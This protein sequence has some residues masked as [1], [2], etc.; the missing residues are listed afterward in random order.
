MN[1]YL[2]QE[3]RLGNL[4]LKY[5]FGVVLSQRTNFNFYTLFKLDIPFLEDKFS[6][7]IIFDGVLKEQWTGSRYT[8]LFNNKEINKDLDS[9]SEALLNSSCKHINII[10]Y[11][12]N[13]NY[14][15]PHIYTI[16]DLFKQNKH[17]RQIVEKLDKNGTGVLIRKAD[18]INTPHELPDSWYFK[19]VEKFKD[20]QIYFSSDT[21]NHPT[22]QHLIYNYN[23][24]FVSGSA[25]D[26]ILAFSYFKNLILSQGTFSW[27]SGILN[28]NNVYSMIPNTGWNSDQYD[29]N[30]ITP[31]WNWLKLEEI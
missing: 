16:R 10:G 1:L 19:M 17:Y 12:Q 14:Y 13:I 2:Q 7:Q 6:E 11:Y 26:I 28:E 8:L 24:K 30:L 15:T 5:F 29:V 21:P 4:L 31:W 27:W 23:A 25:I 22:C 20:T 3:G 18:I 9:I